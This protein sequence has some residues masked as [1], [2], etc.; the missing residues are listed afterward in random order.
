MIGTDNYSIKLKTICTEWLW[1]YI[2]CFCLHCLVWIA[3]EKWTCPCEID[4]SRISF[5]LFSISLLLMCVTLSRVNCCRWLVLSV[6]LNDNH[7]GSSTTNNLSLKYKEW[8]R[9]K[10]SKYVIL[11]Q[12]HIELVYNQFSQLS[13][14]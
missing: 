4:V 11:V 5:K 9:K 3:Q 2:E 1:G 7:Y 12:A 14:N 8:E 6:V 10:K 13:K